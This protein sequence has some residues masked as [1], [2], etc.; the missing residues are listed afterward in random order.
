MDFDINKKKSNK[1]RI[2]FLALTLIMFLGVSLAAIYFVYV[3]NDERDNELLTGLI[4]INFTEGSEII[5]LENQVPVIDEIGLENTPYTFTVKN[6]SIVPINVRIGLDPQSDNTIPLSA[7]RYAFYIDDELIEIGNIDS[8]NNNTIYLVNNFQ[9]GSSLN[10]K[11]IF[12]VDYY[13]ENSGEKFS[14]KIK[15]T[16]ESFDVI[17]PELGSDKFKKAIVENTDE[18]CTPYVEEDGIIYLSGDD[19]CVDFN[20]VWYSGKLWRITAIYPDGTMK[21]ITDSAIT[22]IAYGSDYN[23]YTDEENTSYMY[24]R[25]N[26]DFLDTLYNYENIIVTDAIWNASPGDGGVSS[27]LPIDGQ[28]EVL[29]TSPVGLLNSYEYYKSYQNTSYGSGYLNIGYYW[30]LLNRY[31]T[32]SSSVWYVNDYGLGLNNSPSSAYGGRPVINLKSGIQLEGGSGTASD[33]YKIKGDKEE[34]VSG[35]TLINTRTSG[36][37]VKFNEELYRIVGIENETTKLIKAD[38]VKD[39]TTILTKKFAST[40]TFGK[41]TNTKTD[42]Y[43]DY[44][45]NN[46]WLKSVDSTYDETEGTSS[47]LAKGTYYIKS[48][49]GGNYKGT[50]CTIVRN[51]T[52]IEE[53]DKTGI[54]TWTGFVGLPRYGEMFASQTNDYTYS[55]ASGIWLITPYSSGVWSVSNLG[56]GSDYGPS[57]TGG[58][59]PTIHLKS[60]IVIKS[61]NGTKDEPFVVGLPTTE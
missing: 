30:W 7:V 41:D 40:E 36:E 16:G 25:L 49:T 22:T 31:S 42:D 57:G 18:S 56:G 61:G 23:F 54:A 9:S 24:Q 26:E 20:Y 55:T 50:A 1:K 28:E 52:T 2:V 6:T 27:K 45:L 33:P 11:L 29:V 47:V 3:F 39:G 59:R 15:V 43:W 51:T 17:A 53:C 10:G 14:A 34:V 46:T 38:Y 60:E 4:S 13:Y 35:T 58:G 48:F 37:Y 8:K 44:Y 12:W 5:N 19:T 32:S 21:M